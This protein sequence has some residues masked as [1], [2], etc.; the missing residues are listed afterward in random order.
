MD[1]FSLAASVIAAIQPDARNIL[2]GN[3]KWPFIYVLL[4]KS[5]TVK[6]RY[7][8]VRFPVLWG[9]MPFIG[10]DMAGAGATWRDSAP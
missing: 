3:L 2:G 1:G 4:C 6:I 9:R 8:S 7:H 10:G 5:F